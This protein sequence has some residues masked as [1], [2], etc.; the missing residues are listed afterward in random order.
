MHSHKILLFY[1]NKL[2]NKIILPPYFQRARHREKSAR[3]R[4]FSILYI[5]AFELNTKIYKVISAF[6]PN[7]RKYGPEKLRIRTLFAH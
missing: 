1:E 7:V 4:S 5:P 2:E 3:I 6:S